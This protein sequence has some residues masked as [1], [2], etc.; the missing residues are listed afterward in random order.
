MYWQGVDEVKATD[1]VN[2]MVFDTAT[3]ELIN[4]RGFGTLKESDE[5]NK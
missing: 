3:G 2:F 1:G 5:S 4:A